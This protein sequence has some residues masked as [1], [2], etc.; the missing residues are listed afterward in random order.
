MPV[1]SIE[2]PDGRV[3]DAEAPNEAAAMAG[4]RQW[5][6]ANPRW[7]TQPP[8]QPAGRSGL[9]WGQWAEDLVTGR[10][11]T[12]HP[13]AEE[14]ATAIFRG[15]P[16]ENIERLRNVDFDLSAVNRAAVTPDP[17]AQLDILRR[18]IPG[19]EH[20][21]DRHGNLMLRAP[22]FGVTE[23]TYLNRPGISGRDFDELATGT[24][25]T[26]PFF[27][28]FG[29]GANLGQRVASGFVAGAGSSLTQDAAAIASGSEQSP[30]PLRAV[31]GGGV[32]AALAP[33]VPSAIASTVARPF[34]RAAPAASDAERQAAADALRARA[35]AGE[36]LT[37]AEQRALAASD[38]ID[39]NVDLPRAATGPG[40]RLLGQATAQVPFLG[41][42]I[43]KATERATQ[44]IDEAVDGVVARYGSGSR[45]SAGE[46]IRDELSGV[47]ATGARTVTDTARRHV[48]EF[49]T[50]LENVISG[51][52]SGGRVSAGEG[53]RQGI[54]DWI[55]P[56]SGEYL[57]R[58]Y[59]SVDNLIADHALRRPLTSTRAAARDLASDVERGIAPSNRP[60]IG[61]VERA[62]FSREG[63][64]YAE[65]KQLRTEI[66]ARINGSILPEA[67]TSRPALQ[68]LYGALTEDLQSIIL[69]AGGKDAEDAFLRANHV[70][71]TV[72]QWREALAG[73]VGAEGN[74]PAERVLDRLLTMASAR[75]GADI[76]RLIQARAVITQQGGEEAWHE[77]ASAALRQ[78]GRTGEGLSIAR[79][80]TEYSNL[81]P[82]GRDLLFGRGTPLR[83]RLEAL[84]GQ[85]ERPERLQ[86]ALRTGSQG[87]LEE[88]LIGDAGIRAIAEQRT[89]LQKVLGREGAAS[90]EGIVDTLTTMAGAGRG[91]DVT[92]LAQVKSLVGQNAWDDLASAVLRALG[93]S[94]DGLSIA[95]LRTAYEK[96]LSTDGRNL[97]FTGEWRK[98]LDRIMTVAAAFEKF[99]RAGNPSG[100]TRT[101]VGVGLGFGGVGV[102]IAHPFMVLGGALGHFGLAS[103]LARPTSAATVSRWMSAYTAAAAKP[104]NAQLTL[105]GQASRALADVAAREGVTSNNVQAQLDEAASRLQPGQQRRDSIGPWHTTM[106][107]EPDASRFAGNQTAEALRRHGVHPTNIEAAIGN[108]QLAAAMLRNPTDYQE[109]GTP[110]MQLIERRRAMGSA[111]GGVA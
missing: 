111:V 29:G 18:N 110:A 20:Q 85:A 21:T 100:T 107:R 95:Q 78:M 16:E 80:R 10:H 61:L 19:L 67:G 11:T 28:M 62:A 17:A 69:R 65:T 84:M 12:E 14:F 13:N 52:G 77:V 47:L 87:E 24:L 57:T 48:G 99:Q 81:S 38:A 108:A 44:Q 3:M 98:S 4:A 22:L 26:L 103:L 90:A 37:T 39:E 8:P 83:Q 5:F 56:G 109:P 88:A 6:A 30:D 91:A 23:W 101:I 32:G 93:R 45:V 40:T 63:L 46:G 33:G 72:S 86:A 55:G 94:K 75:P 31:I 97:L 9:T 66:G 51:F 92:R 34:R 96:G 35:A 15:V 41:R 102:A 1:F 74:A 50:G 27:G 53:A 79:L 42:P 73:V 104:N 70:A 59:D 71:R 60:A 76:N 105:L 36:T 82:N 64:T 89:S 49:E 58:L 54:R 68:R 106:Q 43:T 7:A 2:L 25:A